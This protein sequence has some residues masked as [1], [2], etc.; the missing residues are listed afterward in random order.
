MKTLKC[1]LLLCLIQLLCIAVYALSS[2]QSSPV[3]AEQTV[4]SAA[5]CSSDDAAIY[6]SVMK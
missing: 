1:L 4:D 6:L 3:K 5:G 2:H